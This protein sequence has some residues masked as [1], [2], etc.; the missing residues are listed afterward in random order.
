VRF[1]NNFFYF[2]LKNALAYYNADVV[3]VKLE[4]VG[5]ALEKGVLPYVPTSNQAFT[6]MYICEKLM[7]LSI[8]VTN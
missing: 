5:L 1:G 7:L 3:V 4:I 2:N 6:N 8:S